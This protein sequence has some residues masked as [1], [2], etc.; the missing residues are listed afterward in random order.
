MPRTKKTS[1]SSM[2]AGKAGLNRPMGKAAGKMGGEEEM[3]KPAKQAAYGR[4]STTTPRSAA[5]RSSAKTSSA[6]ATPAKGR[7]GTKSSPTRASAR[8]AAPK[9]TGSSS[10]AG[11]ASRGGARKARKSSRAK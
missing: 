4:R 11:A 5:R 8:K 7:A 2:Q 3:E 6:K 1:Q 10:R 9:S